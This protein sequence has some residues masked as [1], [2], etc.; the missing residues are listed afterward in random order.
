MK[1]IGVC[2]LAYGDEHIK[3]CLFF[4]NNMK[5]YK[6]IVFFIGTN[7]V[8]DFK[9]IPNVKVTKIDE[10]FNYNLKRKSVE[11][12]LKECDIIVIMDTDIIEHILYHGDTTTNK[13]IFNTLNDIE[14]GMYSDYINFFD[15]N[16]EHHYQKKVYD[17]SGF[18]DGLLH[19]LEHIIILKI[20]DE[21]IKER[22]I[23]NWEHFYNETLEVQPFSLVSKQKGAMEG[24]LIHGC[25]HKA[26]LKFTRVFDN[27]ITDYF[28][29]RFYHYDADVNKPN[30]V[31]TKGR[32]II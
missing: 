14:D 15:L 2:L 6:E 10:P 24:L 21:K 28:F 11:V 23:E 3:E 8:D 31:S 26:G 19:V 4:I 12:A 5:F 27:P 25:V 17:L 29:C 18:Y 9:D 7:S 32:S 30:I 13:S 1:K 20:T 22:F 16:L